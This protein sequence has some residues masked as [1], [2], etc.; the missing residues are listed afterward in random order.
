MTL[1]YLRVDIN[2]TAVLIKKKKER[3]K[4]RNYHEKTQH[5]ERMPGQDAGRDWGDVAAS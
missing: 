5:T 2:L 1:F 3:K 4:E